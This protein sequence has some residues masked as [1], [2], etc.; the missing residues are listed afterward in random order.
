MFH[1]NIA[2]LYYSRYELALEW[3]YQEATRAAAQGKED[4]TEESNESSKVQRYPCSVDGPR[5]DRH[6]PWF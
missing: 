5:F 1:P 2:L 6:V 4:T 3:L